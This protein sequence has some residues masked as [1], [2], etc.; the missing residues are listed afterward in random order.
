MY[1]PASKFS[2]YLWRHLEPA[3][4]FTFTVAACNGFTRE[5]G[6]SSN[7]VYALTED[8]LSGPPSSVEIFCKHDNISG[9]N[10]V[11]VKWNEPMKKFGQIEFYNVR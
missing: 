3:T 1:Q 4:N 6:N 9:M 2:F 10:Y 8:G 7:P 5:C 11:D